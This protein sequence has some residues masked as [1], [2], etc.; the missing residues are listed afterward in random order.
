MVPGRIDPLVLAHLR[1]LERLTSA[2]LRRH[3]RSVDRVAAGIGT[4]DYESA[5]VA[6]LASALATLVARAYCVT[7]SQRSVR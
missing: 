2:R 4:G 3:G 5:S 1:R 7:P 6:Q